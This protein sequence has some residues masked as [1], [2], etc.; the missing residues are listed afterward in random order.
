[1]KNVTLAKESTSWGNNVINWEEVA[2]KNNSPQLGVRI[3][4]LNKSY[5]RDEYCAIDLEEESSMDN[6]SLEKFLNKIDQDRRE[7]EE[8]LSKNYQL[9][10]QRITEERRL[11]EERIENRIIA[12]EERMEKKFIETMNAISDTNK[13]I[14]KLENKLDDKTDKMLEKIDST[15]KWIIGLCISTILGVAAIA[16]AIAI[17][18]FQSR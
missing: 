10:E 7:Q 14:E 3:G 18:I 16:T 17:F 9:M 13:R 12:S 1:M 8:R 2:S 15:N 6:D 11:S 5:N 4:S